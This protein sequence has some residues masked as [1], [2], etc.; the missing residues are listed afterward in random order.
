MKTSL[1][2][3]LFAGGLVVAPGDAAN[4]GRPAD[5]TLATMTVQDSS[6]APHEQIVFLYYKDLEPVDAFFGK[7][8]GLKKTMDLDWVKIFQTVAGSSIGCVKEGRGSLKTSVD[9]PVLVSWVVDDV[10]A[11]QRR[12]TASGVKITKPVHASAEPPMKSL[13]FEDPTGYT[14]ELVQWLKR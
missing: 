10:E 8:L 12:L 1:W 5:S 6:L 4:F 11:W 7:I 13:L 2:V 9:K 3:M 14:F